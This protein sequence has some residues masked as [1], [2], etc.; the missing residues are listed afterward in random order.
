MWSFRLTVCNKMILSDF[1]YTTLFKRY[2]KKNVQI[3]RN[4]TKKVKCIEF[5][6]SFSNSSFISINQSDKGWYYIKICI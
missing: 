5:H 6:A 2:D 1:F 4:E 3:L